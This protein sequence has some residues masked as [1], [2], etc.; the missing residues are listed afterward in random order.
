MVK[1]LGILLPVQG[2]W[3]QSLIRKI[4]HADEQLSPHASTTEVHAPTACVLQ[5]EK[6]PK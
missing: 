2:K 1:W 6:P 4:S 3:I 5:Q